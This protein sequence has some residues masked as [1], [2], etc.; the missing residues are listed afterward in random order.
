[1]VFVSLMV[2]VLGYINCFG[3]FMGGYDLKCI[4]SRLY[5][6]KYSE[7]NIGHSD[8]QKYVSPKKY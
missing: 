3:N 6:S 4:L 5:C 1:M 7:I 8:L 2:L